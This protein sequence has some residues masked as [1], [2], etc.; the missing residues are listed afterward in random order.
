MG[1]AFTTTTELPTPCELPRWRLDRPDAGLTGFLGANGM[2]C[3]PRLIETDRGACATGARIRTTAIFASGRRPW[4]RVDDGSATITCMCCSG[5][6]V[7]WSTRSGYSGSTARNGRRCAGVAGANGPWARRP[8]KTPEAARRGASLTRR[9]RQHRHA[10]WIRRQPP[11]FTA[12]CR[13][14]LL[15]RERPGMPSRVAWL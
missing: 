15:M 14:A 6:K 4:P 11:A 1:A 13:S 9:G 10:G 8:M 2:P 5:V 12:F 3:A 7:M